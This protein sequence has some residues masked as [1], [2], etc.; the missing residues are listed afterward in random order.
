VGLS[1]VAGT[2]AVV[3]A[4]AV[5]LGGIFMGI[6]ALGLMEA[7]RL[8]PAA[9]RQAPVLITASFGLGQMIDPCSRGFLGEATGNFET[10]FFAAAA[11]VLAAAL[12]WR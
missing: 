12:V 2:P 10:A 6:T 8:S 7:R 4:A 9:Q 3:F 11:L 1:V 5:L